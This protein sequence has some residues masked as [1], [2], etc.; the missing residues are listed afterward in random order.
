MQVFEGNDSEGLHWFTIAGI[1]HE[2][3]KGD[4]EEGEDLGHFCVKFEHFSDYKG[5]LA[6]CRKARLD[7]N[8]ELTLDEAK[9]AE[10]TEIQRLSAA[11]AAEAAE[12]TIEFH[13]SPL[14]N[15]CDDKENEQ[16]A[17][18]TPKGKNRLKSM[19]MGGAKSAMKKARGITHK[20]GKMMTRTPSKMNLRDGV[21]DEDF[22][23]PKVP[24][25]SKNKT[26]GS[27][28]GRS[29]SMNEN[30]MQRP[31]DIRPSFQRSDSCGQTGIGASI[32]MV[33]LAN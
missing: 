6:N 12:S 10:Q 30:D 7:Q 18:F 1:D 3:E 29:Q 17:M 8:L 20:A 26:P 22:K 31:E 24:K 5:F 28:L 33:D 15:D 11:A 25:R 9:D 21:G 19:F 14:A 2:D 23:T 4:L 32:P 27:N 16:E 13:G